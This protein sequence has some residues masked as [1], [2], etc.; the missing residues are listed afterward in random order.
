MLFWA[1]CVVKITG[2][3]RAEDAD[4]RAMGSEGRFFDSFA[5]PSEKSRSSSADLPCQW[6]AVSESSAMKARW[7]FWEE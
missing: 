2:V 3:E 5:S 4:L 1:R 7:R 6:K